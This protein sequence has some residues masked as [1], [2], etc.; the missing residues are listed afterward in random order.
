MTSE[1]S[2]I[3]CTQPAVLH[4]KCFPTSPVVARQV[5]ISLGI[6]TQS[7]QTITGLLIKPK[8]QARQSGQLWC[9][10]SRLAPPPP[11]IPANRGASPWH[12]DIIAA[13]QKQTPTPVPPRVAWQAAW[14]RRDGPGREPGPSFVCS[15][16]VSVCVRA[17]CHPDCKQELQNGAT[18]ASDRLLNASWRRRGCTFMSPTAADAWR[19]PW[20]YGVTCL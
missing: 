3:I 2:L 12:T 13:R 17:P 14:T 7:C 16:A 1:F 9:V 15:P 8:Q 6:S 5:H 11:S 4:S 20:I 19:A 10:Q 18:A